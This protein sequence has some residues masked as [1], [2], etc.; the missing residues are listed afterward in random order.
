[1][2]VVNETISGTSGTLDKGNNYEPIIEENI[3]NVNENKG[4]RCNR[5]TLVV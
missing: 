2:V 3:E 5:P 1:M 4:G